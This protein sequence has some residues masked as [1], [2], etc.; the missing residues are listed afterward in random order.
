MGRAKEEETTHINCVNWFQWHFPNKDIIH[1]P[2]GGTRNWKLNAKGVRYSPEAQRLKRM[3]VKKGVS[4]IFIPEPEGTYH[5]LW[6]EIKSQKGKVTPE[7]H[8]FLAKQKAKNYQCAIAYSLDD[9]IT[10]IKTYFHA[11]R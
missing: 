7:Q 5:G 11:T 1:I 9:F 8:T 2:N 6:I 3:G 10:I 4:D